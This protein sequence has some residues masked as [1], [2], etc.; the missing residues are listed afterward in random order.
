MGVGFSLAVLSAVTMVCLPARVLSFYFFVNSYLV[1]LITFQLL[2][3]YLFENSKE[4]GFALPS[5][6]NIFPLNHF[7]YSGQILLYEIV[8][9][10]C[11]YY[12][13][14]QLSNV[15]S[16]Y[17]FGFSSTVCVLSHY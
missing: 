13:N 9:I 15:M 5:L 10:L 8:Q 11:L 1:L 3:N 17:L 16:E 6:F 7:S 2:S 4:K 12:G 14:T